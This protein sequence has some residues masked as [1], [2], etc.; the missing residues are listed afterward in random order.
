MSK[1]KI[2]YAPNTFQVLKNPDNKNQDLYIVV[3][4][5]GYGGGIRARFLENEMNEIFKDKFLEFL[6]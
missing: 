2:A 1:I 5:D 3:N 6:N 4:P